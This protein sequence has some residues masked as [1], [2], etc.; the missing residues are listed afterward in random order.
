MFDPRRQVILLLGEDKSGA[1]EA[2]Y[3]EAVPEADEL[4]DTLISRR[5]SSSTIKTW[6]AGFHGSA[7]CSV[8][9]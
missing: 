2:W 3:L 4:Y 5:H 8:T 9:N 1:R 6:A 7:Q